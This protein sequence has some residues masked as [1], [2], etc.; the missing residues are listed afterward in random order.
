[1]R[2]ILVVSVIL[3]LVCSMAFAATFAPSP[4]KLE[5]DATIVYSFDGSVLNVPV[6][7]TGTPALVKF[8]VFTSGKSDQIRNVRNGH[9]GWHYVDKVDTCLYI[10]VDNQFQAGNYT[11]QWNGK[12]QDGGTV[13]TGTY[14]YYLWGF[15]NV[16]TVMKATPSNIDANSSEGFIVVDDQGTKLSQ[17]IF[18][19]GT[20]GGWRWKLGNDPDNSSLLETCTFT[21][22][23]G[24][25]A[26]HRAGAWPVDPR[27]NNVVYGRVFNSSTTATK[28][29]K[30]NWIPNDLGTQDNVF[31]V[32][33]EALNVYSGIEY[34]DTYLYFGEC[35]Y[36][37]QVVRT[38]LH[39]IDY[40][41]TPAGEYLGFIDQSNTF[42]FS[43]TATQYAG[44]VE[45]QPLMNGGWT[46][47]GFWEEKGWMTGGCHCTCMRAACEPRAWFD[48][49]ST[50]AIRWENGNGDYVFD[51]NYEPTR[52]YAWVCGNLGYQENF[53]TNGWAVDKNGFSEGYNSYGTTPLNLAAPDGTGIG[54][55]AFS[56]TLAGNGGRNGYTHLDDDTAYDGSYCTVQV[57]GA[58]LPGSYYAG[59]D[60]FKGTITDAV[61][62]DADAPAA[63]TVGQNNP[64]PFNPTTTINFTLAKS[65][66]VTVDVFNVAGQ[67]VASLANGYHNAGAHSLVWNAS[68]QASGVYFYTVKSGNISKTMKMTLAR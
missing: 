13:P 1:M 3:M 29:L 39:I 33:L 58:S 42:E 10:S 20:G 60:S 63:F 21:M 28:A 41:N 46:N 26:S 52:T 68:G 50:D 35:N 45:L 61:S 56:G 8:M 6:R 66:N 54:K 43:D 32:D 36:K 55:F 7:L 59:R 30:F 62:V 37:E 23:S 9:L 2:R 11:I 18:Y 22:P 40:A 53:S 27:N 12:D 19:N 64:N 67:K 65:G 15:D 48:D 34:D 24:F 14:T 57:E 16:S 5:G 4:T 31:N 49:N 25:G 51:K 38:R 47:S 17:P 44:V